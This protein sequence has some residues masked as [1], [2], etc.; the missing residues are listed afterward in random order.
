[1]TLFV[2]LRQAVYLHECGGVFSSLEQAR[3]AAMEQA[4]SELDGHH[5]YAVVPF[6]LDV[7]TEKDPDCSRW[8][9]LKEGDPL[10][11]VRKRSDSPM[12]HPSHPEGVEV[13]LV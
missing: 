6:V 8:G 5:Y 7:V 13:I 9:S 4:R 1:M 2:V 3:D 11:I 10:L 12:R